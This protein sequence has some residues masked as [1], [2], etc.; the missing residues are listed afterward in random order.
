MKFWGYGVIGLYVFRGGRVFYFNFIIITIA[1]TFLNFFHIIIITIVRAKLNFF[2]SI[3]ML[4]YFPLF[5]L[6]GLCSI[7]YFEQRL[8]ST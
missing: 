3:I 2:Y 8:S 5:V 4:C 6:Y 1:R 7:I